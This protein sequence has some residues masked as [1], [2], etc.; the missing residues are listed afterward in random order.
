MQNDP[1][2]N[3]I[4]EQ[5]PDTAAIEEAITTLSGKVTALENKLKKIFTFHITWDGEDL[6]CAEFTELTPSEFITL[7]PDV[8]NVH[9]TQIDFK[10]EWLKIYDSNLLYDI[11]D[12]TFQILFII[13]EITYFISG[14]TTTNEWFIGED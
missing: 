3:R 4:M 10:E 8:I 12:H 1:L 13:N 7:D 6:L 5:M 11:A 14:D 2:Y 9:Y